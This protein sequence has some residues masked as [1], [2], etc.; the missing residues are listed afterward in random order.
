MNKKRIEDKEK[1]NEIVE[2]LKIHEDLGFCDKDPYYLGLYNELELALSI[3]LDKEPEFK[4][5]ENE[6]TCS[7][8]PL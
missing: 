3:I 6:S 5:K 7:I 1:L 2:L 4:W 8:Q